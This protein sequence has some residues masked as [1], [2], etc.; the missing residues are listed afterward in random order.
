MGEGNMANTENNGIGCNNG[1]HVLGFKD[2]TIFA[3]KLP[4]L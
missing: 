2:D 3:V 4:L 1:F